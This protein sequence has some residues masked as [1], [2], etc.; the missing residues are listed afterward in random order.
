MVYEILECLKGKI[1]DKIFIM[2]II[3]KILL[4]SKAGSYYDF[5]WE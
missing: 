3:N 4:W 1:K 5:I 2:I